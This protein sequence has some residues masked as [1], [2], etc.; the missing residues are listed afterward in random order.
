[1]S[2]QLNKSKTKIFPSSQSPSGNSH[3]SEKG[4]TPELWGE[5]TA[6]IVLDGSLSLTQ[7]N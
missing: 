7:G 3:S 4:A 2:L 1:M 6:G 5:D